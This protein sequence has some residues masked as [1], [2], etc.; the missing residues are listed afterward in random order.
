MLFFSLGVFIKGYTFY[1]VYQPGDGGILNHQ[2][3]NNTNRFYDG[4]NGRRHI[5][6]IGDLSQPNKE[7]HAT[8][9]H[10]LFGKHVKPYL[11]LDSMGCIHSNSIKKGGYFSKSYKH[12]LLNHSVNK[13]SFRKQKY[14]STGAYSADSKDIT[15]IIEGRTKVY[16][17]L[18]DIMVEFLNSLF[19]SLTETECN[20]IKRN[21]S[22]R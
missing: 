18:T 4:L 13:I 9:E 6:L 12:S 16:E 2:L 19:G 20:T 11:Y 7:L 22:M 5:T 14:F 3:L 8:F 17:L 10:Y 21:K 15:P 1:F